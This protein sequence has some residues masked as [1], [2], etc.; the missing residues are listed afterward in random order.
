VFTLKL[1][2]FV[3]ICEFAEREQVMCRVFDD[4]VELCVSRIEDC[5]DFFFYEYDCTVSSLVLYYSNNCHIDCVYLAFFIRPSTL[6]I[7]N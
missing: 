2:F 1:C 5:K 4:R 7:H 6:H 3:E